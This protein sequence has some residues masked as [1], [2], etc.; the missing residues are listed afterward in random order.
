[1]PSFSCTCISRP[2]SA[3]RDLVP[4]CTYPLQ[5]AVQNLRLTAFLFNN[6]AVRSWRISVLLSS[7]EVSGRRGGA[8]ERERGG[9][10]MELS[11]LG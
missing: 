7:F 10:G 8:S 2:Q 5:L 4:L 9:E 11:I 3:P 1:M 6:E